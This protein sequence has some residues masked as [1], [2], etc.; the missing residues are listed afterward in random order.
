MFLVVRLV[1]L[2][3]I[4]LLPLSSLA[5][6]RREYKGADRGSC[7][8]ERDCRIANIQVIDDPFHNEEIRVAVDGIII[9]I[10]NKWLHVSED[11]QTWYCAKLICKSVDGGGVYMGF[12]QECEMPKVPTRENTRCV[13][14]G[15]GN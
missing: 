8:G 4:L 7:C 14:F 13:F 12:S 6:W 11:Q 3:V 5:D 10:P 1:I 9:K 2:L 15:V